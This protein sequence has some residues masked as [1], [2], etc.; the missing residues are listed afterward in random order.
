MTHDEQMLRKAK[1]KLE[2]I[3][4]EYS[5]DTR[6]HLESAAMKIVMAYERK[7]SESHESKNHKVR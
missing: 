3:Q 1:E 5:G 6:K 7:V 2:R 4:R